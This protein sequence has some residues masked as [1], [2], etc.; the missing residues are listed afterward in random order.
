MKNGPPSRLAVRLA[1]CPQ[2]AVPVCGHSHPL[3]AQ[4]AARVPT[5][6][7]VGDRDHISLVG[8]S[9]G[10]V[11]SLQAM[12]ADVKFTNYSGVGHD[13]WTQ[14]YGTPELYEWMLRHRV[15]DRRVAVP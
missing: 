6:V 13:S 7:V 5:W 14:T 9:L 10:M 8:N 3:A 2:A 15:S 1:I 11:N 4:S 12:H